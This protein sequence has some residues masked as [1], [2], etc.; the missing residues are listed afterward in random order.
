MDIISRVGIGCS[1][2]LL[3]G[4]PLL[5]CIFGRRHTYGR[6]R[7]YLSREQESVVGLVCDLYYQRRDTLLVE[8]LVY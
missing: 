2:H 7:C 1:R 8:D 5:L 4:L 6:A 3:L